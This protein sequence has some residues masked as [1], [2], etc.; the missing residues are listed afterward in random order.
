MKKLFSL[1]II[2]F[3]VLTINGQSSIDIKKL[4]KDFVKVQRCKQKE[5]RS[6][7][8]YK[9]ELTNGEYNLFLDDLKKS[10]N[11]TLYTS[12]LRDSLG[13]KKFDFGYND[14]M[15]RYYA[16]HPAY[17]DYPVVCISYE[18]AVA[19][20]SWLTTKYNESGKGKFKDVVF[21]LPSKGEWIAAADCK[22]QAPYPWYG[23]FPYGE[24][25]CYNCNIRC[26]TMNWIEDGAFYPVAKG[27]YFPNNLGIFNMVGNVAEMIS[28]KGIAKG[29]SWYTFP[30]DADV[31]KVQHYSSADPGI[32]IRVFM[33][34]TEPD[35]NK[36]KRVY[37]N[38]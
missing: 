3:Y 6:V 11:T 32:G 8:A 7:Y 12:C 18:A 36:S 2:L 17:K 16:T 24:K 27:S 15:V 14:P 31:R 1:F 30:E 25:G 37:A 9:F 22:P 19:Y 38:K 35:Q 23:S 4:D 28:D 5:D 26:D 10:G 34:V 13:W 21:R 33:E 29:G 20:C